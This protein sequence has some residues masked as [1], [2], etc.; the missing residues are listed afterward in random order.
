MNRMEK[1]KKYDAFAHSFA[2]TRNCKLLPEST[3]EELRAPI[4]RVIDLCAR[5]ASTHGS[6]P[7]NLPYT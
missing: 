4:A 1:T 3:V 6:E 5:L 7:D 2:L